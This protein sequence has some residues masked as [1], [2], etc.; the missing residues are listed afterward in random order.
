MSAD[1]KVRDLLDGR[2][3]ARKYASGKEVLMAPHSVIREISRELGLDMHCVEGEVFSY[4]AVPERYIRNLST[5]GAE[6]QRRLFF[7]QSRHD[8]SR[9]SRWGI[10]SKPL[11]EPESDI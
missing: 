7:F 2:C 1:V 8:R 9:W 3:V 5:F 10:S 11:P 4:G 6:E